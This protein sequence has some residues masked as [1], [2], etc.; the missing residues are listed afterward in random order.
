MCV[1]LR[2]GYLDVWVFGYWIFG[3]LDILKNCVRCDCADLATGIGFNNDDAMMQ[4]M[5]R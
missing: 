1:V 5:F 4:V 3:Y 2:N